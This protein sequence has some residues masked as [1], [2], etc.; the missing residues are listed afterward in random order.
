MILA[1]YKICLWILTRNSKK[2]MFFLYHC[3]LIE[4][5]SPAIQLNVTISEAA[6]MF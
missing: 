1:V 6:S 5:Y 4:G 3:K 2:D